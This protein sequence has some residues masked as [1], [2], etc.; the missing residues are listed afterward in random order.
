MADF[1]RVEAMTRSRL[2]LAAERRRECWSSCAAAQRLDRRAP[3]RQA[4]D[5]RSSRAPLDHADREEAGLAKSAH[6]GRR[7]RR[8]HEICIVTMI[9]ALALL[10]VCQLAGEAVHRLAGLA[11][12]GSVIGMLLLIGWLALVQKERPTLEAVSAWLTAHLSIMFVPAAV[13]L[14]EQGPALS[15][16]GVGL[17]V[18]TAVSTV[19]TMAVTAL[20]FRWAARR[21]EPAEDAGA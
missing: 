20:V 2:D 10:F 13:G 5:C 8:P 14:I 3:R 18:A 6:C 17:V 9:G 19:L 21:G 16:Y 11:L 15:R 4:K 1:L 7:R 12:P